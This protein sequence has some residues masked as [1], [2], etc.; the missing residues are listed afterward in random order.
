MTQPQPLDLEKKSRELEEKERVLNAR[1][2]LVAR[3]NAINK[4]QK[5]FDETEAKLEVLNKQIKAKDA[6]LSAREMDLENFTVKQNEEIESINAQKSVARQGVIAQEKVLTDLKKQETVL[7]NGIKAKKSELS[8]IRDQV[9]E[10]KAYVSEQSKLAE[11]TISEWNANLVEF[12]AEADL[13]QNEKNKL[14]ADIIRLEQDKTTIALEVDKEQTKLESLAS[15]YE[16]KVEVYKASLR[17]LDVEVSQKRNELEGVVNATQMKLKE[18]ETREKSVHLKEGNINQR[19]A[20]LDQKER[21]LK[22][23]YGI[24]GIDYEDT[25]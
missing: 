11:D 22:M 23:N 24:A 21:R 25:I 9:K 19:H 17:S 12:R 2:D 10:T 5:I 16:D 6:V 3:E 20:E 14:S 18:V 13:I 1:E 8:I 15:A 7:L 4:R